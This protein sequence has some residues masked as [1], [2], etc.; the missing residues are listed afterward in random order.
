MEKELT[1]M[2]MDKVIL[3]DVDGVLLNWEYAFDCWMNELGLYKLPDTN[4]LYN[5]GDRYGIAISSLP[6]SSIFSFKSQ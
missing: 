3:T 1:K 2:D 4:H 5:I 6:H